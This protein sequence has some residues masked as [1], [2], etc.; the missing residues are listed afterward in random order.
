[1]IIPF[2]LNYNFIGVAICLFLLG[3]NIISTALI[4]DHYPESEKALFGYM[5]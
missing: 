5:I 1:M 4:L 2:A 3:G